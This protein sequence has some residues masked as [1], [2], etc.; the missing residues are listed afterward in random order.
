VRRARAS[1][2]P[3]LLL[4]VTL[5][6]PATA[7]AQSRFTAEEFADRLDRAIELTELGASAPSAARMEQVRDALSLPA[8]VV[9]GGRAVFLPAD[10]FLE[11]LSGG[12]AVDFDRAGAHLEGIRHALDATVARDVPSPDR[13]DDS[14]DRAYREVIQIQPSLLERIRR[15]AGEL[16]VWLLYRL[17]NFVGPSSV[18]AW[19]VLVGLLAAAVLLLRRARLVPERV[20]PGS[21]GSRAPE[22][23]VDWGRRAQEALR[24]GDLREAIRALYLALITTLAGRGLLADAPALTAG[25]CRAAVRR[26]RPSLYPLVARAT[27]SYERVLYGGATP[28]QGDV[29]SLLEA[30][31]GARSQ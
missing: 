5:S 9:V 6:L 27:E 11:R 20:L 23:K 29:E 16:I 24:A 31:A 30:E 7:T 12:T 1:L 4:A 21:G 22:T 18:L 2:I 3:G 17:V 10:P 8:D 19:V 25:E 13:V 26:S 14:L 28:R 15:A